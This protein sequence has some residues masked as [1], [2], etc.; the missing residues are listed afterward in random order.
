MPTQIDDL[1]DSAPTTRP[2]DKQR[3]IQGFSD[4]CRPSMRRRPRRGRHPRTLTG[5]DLT[6][7]GADVGFPCRSVERTCRPNV[8]FR[9]GT[10]IA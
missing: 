1:N 3:P 7:G 2:L 10:N 5:T 9:E 4:A 6:V 8:R